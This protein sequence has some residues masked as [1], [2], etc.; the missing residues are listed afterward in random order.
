MGKTLRDEAREAEVVVDGRLEDA[1]PD[2]PGQSG[3]T[4][5][6][7][8]RV[9]KAPAEAGEPR[10]F[11]LDRYLP[12]SGTRG[13]RRVVFGQWLQGVIDPYRTIVVED[14]F[15][16]NYLADALAGEKLPPSDQFA[17]F[18]GYLE[19]EDLMLAEDAYKEFSKAP[20]A[21]VAAAA[22]RY[23]PRTIRAWLREEATPSYRVG[24]YGLL[25]GLCGGEVDRE[26]LRGLID[27]PEDRLLNGIDGIL[28]GYCLLDRRAGPDR[29]MELL[30][31]GNQPFKLR[32]SAMSAARFL[33][34]DLPDADRASL[35][36][37]LEEVALVADTADIVIDELRRQGHEAAW[38]RL[39]RLSNEPSHAS[40]VI[41]RSLVRFAMSFPEARTEEFLAR[42]NAEHPG[43]IADERQ[44]LEFERDVARE[45]SS[46]SPK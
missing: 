8:L 12:S 3:T 5:L 11:V 7:P 40:S 43:W 25:L 4:K 24:L 45:Y 30:A 46:K 15:L 21:D 26:F 19:H 18:F 41:Q 32:Y 6:V 17:F 2:T 33:L 31:D 36:A 38:P 27:D 16:T 42:I 13:R 14:D 44:N 1:R 9:V 34:T 39:L 35:L 37:R 23:E 10:A 29:V 28:A 20:Y 22:E